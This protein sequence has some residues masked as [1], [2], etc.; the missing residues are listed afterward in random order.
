MISYELVM[1]LTVLGLI[2]VYGTI[3]LGAMVRQQSGTVLGFLPAWGLVY[4]PFAAVLFM[5]AARVR[6]YATNSMMTRTSISMRCQ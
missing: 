2:L 4:Q 3:D 6:Q 1:G 5:T